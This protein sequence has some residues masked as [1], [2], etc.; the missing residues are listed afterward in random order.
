MTAFSTYLWKEWRDQRMTVF[1]ILAIQL[2]VSLLLVLFLQDTVIGSTGLVSAVT[3]GSLA[4]SLVA[5]GPELVGGE[6]RSGTIGFLTRMPD[7]LRL[8]FASK[9][10]FLVIAMLLLTCS[11][12]MV[13]SGFHR[14][15]GLEW[16]ASI[17]PF[18]QLVFDDR[19][20]PIA[21]TA[22][23]LLMAV[24]SWL[25]RS[26]LTVPA[27]ALLVGLVL[28][29]C[30]LVSKEGT[31]LAEHLDF[32]RLLDLGP[33]L[34]LVILW[35]S[36]V[37]GRRAG[38][39]PGSSAWRGLSV[40]F[41]AALPLWSWIGYWD[42]EWRTPRP[43]EEMLIRGGFVGKGGRLAFLDT[44]RQTRWPW[45]SLVVDLETGSWRQIGELNQGFESLTW[46]EHLSLSGF[47]QHPLVMQL[48][49]RRSRGS[50]SFSWVDGAT[51]EAI[52]KHEVR[53]DRVRAAARATAAVRMPDGRQVWMLNGSLEVASGDTGYDALPWDRNDKAR[54]VIGYGLAVSRGRKFVVYDLTRQRRFDDYEFDDLKCCWVLAS[55]WLVAERDERQPDGR[56]GRYFRDWCLLDPETGESE[57]APGLFDGEEVIAPMDDGTVLVQ[58]VDRRSGDVP[59]LV[60]IRLGTRVPLKVPGSDVPGR[61]LSLWRSGPGGRRLFATWIGKRGMHLTSLAP[62]SDELTVPIPMSDVLDCPDASTALIISQDGR[63]LERV[64]LLTGESQT[65]FPR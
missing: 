60:D 1:G 5:F 25:P 64:D 62:G 9:T 52:G 18:A 32:G 44:T 61:L 55:R 20:A 21:L 54:A 35:L 31:G 22:G 33:A 30:Y 27:T 3:L 41:A 26:I 63:R 37:R 11:G 19:L 28:L 38:G 14:V 7:G 8:A 43:Q 57:P 42:H 39:G 10:L 13:S 16:R 47:G 59:H 40:V 17:P 56:F 15:A 51:G 48:Q 24:S 2:L 46:R 4:L 6:T 58:R 50:R 34:A 45:I 23:L 29:P 65:V 49:D 12:Y 53:P 36:F